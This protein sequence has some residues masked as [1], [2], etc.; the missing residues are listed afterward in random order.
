MTIKELKKIVEEHDDIMMHSDSF[1]FTIMTCFDELVIC[2]Q[3]TDKE[4]YYKTVNDMLEDYKI[5]N[6]TLRDK[7]QTVVLDSCS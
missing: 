4:M 7:M 6:N 5:G 1:K 3:Q 2:E